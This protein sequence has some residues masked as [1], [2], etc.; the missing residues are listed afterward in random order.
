MWMWCA[1]CFNQAIQTWTPI[2]PEVCRCMKPLGVGIKRCLS[3]NS[4]FGESGE[5][6]ELGLAKTELNAICL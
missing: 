2:Q 1:S 4:R 5:D 6:E 3:L